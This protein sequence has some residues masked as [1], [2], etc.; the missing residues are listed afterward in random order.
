MSEENKPPD[1]FDVKKSRKEYRHNHYLLH[2]EEINKRSAEYQRNHPEKKK[3]WSRRYKERHPT[4]A[5]EYR[6]ANRE[7]LNDYS[8]AYY[9]ENRGSVLSYQDKYRS[10]QWEKLA[11]KQVK[12][13]EKNAAELKKKRSDPKYRELI[14]ERNHAYYLKRKV[15]V[16]GHYGATPLRCACCGDSHIEFLTLD[17]VNN[18]GAAHRKEIGA[19]QI[20]DWLIDNG[21]PAGFQVLC[22][23]CNFAKGKSRD[24]V[25]P[26][27]LERNAESGK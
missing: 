6:V 9:A 19:G 3:E 20:Y 7:K 1:I 2:K 24:H 11:E 17:H 23:N 8:K 4:K 26:H 18:D 25:C 14:H 5:L 12:F 15:F 21:F 13:R 10:E 16:L 27:Q 22:M